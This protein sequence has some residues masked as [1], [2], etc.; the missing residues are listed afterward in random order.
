MKN[1]ELANKMGR[2]FGKTKLKFQKYSPEILVATGIVGGI[3]AAVLAC[4]A[5]TKASAIVEKS[6]KDIEVVHGLV[7]DPK[8][9]YTKEDSKRDLTIIYAQTGVKLLRQ[10][11]P[12]LTLGGLSIACILSGNNILRK[13]NVALATAYTTVDTS[14]RNY[15][16]RVIE[17]F[18][19]ELDKEL[20]YNIKAKEIEETTV[21]EKGKEKTTK[22]VVQVADPNQHSL[23]ARFFEDGQTG[24]TK[25]AEHNLWYLR[26][27]QNMANDK[28]KTQGYLFLNDVYD[29]LDI[30]KTK[31]GQVVGW[32]YDENNTEGDNFVDFGIYDIHKEGCRD[33]VNGYERSILLDFNV[34]GNILDLI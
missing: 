34:Q 15:R 7:D 28:L 14:F 30:P 29:M 25:D 6:K 20:R 18:G 24:W 3:A 4:K 21:D 27:M 23:Y 5:T 19:E 16:D 2:K 17:R 13:R 11:A 9:E 22:R 12:A 32:I 33:F 1:K 10:Y 26:Q 8:H 31:I